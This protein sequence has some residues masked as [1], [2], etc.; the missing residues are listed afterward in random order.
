M[1]F[2]FTLMFEFVFWRAQIDAAVNA[3][4]A[5]PRQLER[6]GPRLGGQLVCSLSPSQSSDVIIRAVWLVSRGFPNALALPWV[7]DISGH[8]DDTM[9]KYGGRSLRLRLR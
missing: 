5:V 6:T 3:D 9:Q 4:H 2:R 1:P 7:N 8:V